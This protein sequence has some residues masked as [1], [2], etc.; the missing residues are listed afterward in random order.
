[1]GISQYDLADLPFKNIKV[2][3]FVSRSRKN[4]EKFLKRKIKEVASGIPF[5]LA[6][7]RNPFNDLKERD[8]HTGRH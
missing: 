5:I 1:M 4:R 3:V 7:L 6:V 2:S 8:V